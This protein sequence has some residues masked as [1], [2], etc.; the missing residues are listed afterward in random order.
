MLIKV[1]LHWQDKLNLPTI[2]LPYKAHTY[3]IA[4]YMYYNL[5]NTS[6]L[7]ICIVQQVVFNNNP[8]KYDKL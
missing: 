5:F 7:S 1:T 6:S 8:L 4:Y 3:Y 2:T